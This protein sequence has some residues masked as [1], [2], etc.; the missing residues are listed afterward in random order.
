MIFRSRW[1]RHETA[2]RLQH[3]WQEHEKRLRADNKRLRVERLQAELE[4]CIKR[5]RSLLEDAQANYEAER[6]LR[7]YAQMCAKV[8]KEAAKAWRKQAN[9]V[10]DCYLKKFAPAERR[11]ATERKRREE[12]EEAIAEFVVASRRIGELTQYPG[13]DY[14]IPEGETDD[15]YWLLLQIDNLIKQVTQHPAIQRVMK[16]K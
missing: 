15:P 13:A 16:G 10:V 2:A 8:W 9:D 11:L 1:H 4:E 12:A 7:E 3:R 14:P 6:K 5:G